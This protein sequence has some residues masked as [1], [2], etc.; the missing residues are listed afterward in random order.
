MMNIVIFIDGGDGV[1]HSAVTALISA[2]LDRTGV[3]KTVNLYRNRPYDGIAP[4]HPNDR[5]LRIVS[6]YSDTVLAELDMIAR[7]N[8]LDD[9]VRAIAGSTGVIHVML[10]GY[11]NTDEAHELTQYLMRNTDIN[12]QVLAMN[13]TD[14]TP[15]D[16]TRIVYE[17]YGELLQ[18]MD[19]AV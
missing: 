17:L 19:G 15:Q 9:M 14:P 1:S 11:E 13:N 7:V 16:R 10:D 12:T 2:S 18:M 8:E 6:G 3:V 4:L 5:T